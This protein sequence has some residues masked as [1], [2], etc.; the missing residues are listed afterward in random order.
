ETH[1]TGNLPKRSNRA[2]PLVP[3][4]RSRLAVYGPEEHNVDVAGECQSLQ[5]T[6]Q[7]R[8]NS[9][10]APLPISREKFGK[11]HNHFTISQNRVRRRST[12]Q[13]RTRITPRNKHVVQS[14]ELANR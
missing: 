8:I 11:Q 9:E 5:N 6:T 12:R 1:I 14:T 10:D 3:F 4:V 7:S 13:R 2:L